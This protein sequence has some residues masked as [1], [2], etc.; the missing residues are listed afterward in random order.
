MDP[1]S[2]MPTQKGFALTLKSLEL[3]IQ[4][5]PDVSLQRSQS[6]RLQ[7]LKVDLD[8]VGVGVAHGGLSCLNDVHHAAQL[9]AR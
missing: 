2:R 5:R 9:H 3:L 7:N 8:L 6:R 4:T 1:S